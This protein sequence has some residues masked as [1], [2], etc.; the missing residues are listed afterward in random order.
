MATTEKYTTGRYEAEGIHVRAADSSE[1]WDKLADALGHRS[2]IVTP[3]ADVNG[4]HTRGD[5]IRWYRLSDKAAYELYLLAVGGDGARMHGNIEYTL[6]KR[7]L[8]KMAGIRPGG[9]PGRKGDMHRTYELTAAGWK[10]A[11]AYATSGRIDA[12]ICGGASDAQAFTER[13]EQ[14]RS[15]LP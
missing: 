10:L 3:E 6:R 1:A 14:A 5:L 13:A 2:H 15:T 4:D 12:E 11:A 9:V 8:A 7:G